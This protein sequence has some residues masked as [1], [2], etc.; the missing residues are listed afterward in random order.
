MILI[1][2]EIVDVLKKINNNIY[3]SGHKKADCDSLF[4]SLAL[5]LLLN[6]MGKTCK[7]YIEKEDIDK[8]EYFQCNDIIV[9]DIVDD[10]FTFILLDL[11][12][13]ERL[14]DK[15]IY[16]FQKAT[17]T[18][19]IDHHIK[20][21]TKSKFV[22]S[23]EE[24]SSTCEI[25]YDI[26]SELQ[27]K[28]SS[29]IAEL[30]FTGIVSDTNMLVNNADYNTF[31]ILSHL[32]KKNIDKDFLI[33]KYVIEKTEEEMKIIAYMIN[34]II[35]DEV[36]Y[37]VLDMKREPFRSVSYVD[38]SK[39]CIPTIMSDENINILIV[40]MD[41]GIKKKG[42]I[43]SKGKIDSEKLAN[44]LTGGGHFHAA[45]FSNKKSIDEIIDIS[46]KYMGDISV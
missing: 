36:Y 20:N 39:K 3:I 34:N 25:I 28:I 38:I 16:A 15:M 23:F 42:E 8:V 13:I 18:I 31:L 19:N 46:K 32:L 30:L 41:Y 37:V 11:N 2:N 12:K 45:G 27:V 6:D 35:F 22:Y 33:N 26:A 1:M 24:K 17:T 9:D 44:I 29:K 43:R 21:N 5:A 7:V 14:P 10:N 4:S 40:I